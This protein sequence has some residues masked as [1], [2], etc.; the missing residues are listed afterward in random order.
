MITALEDNSIFLDVNL[1]FLTL[2]IPG[3]WPSLLPGKPFVYLAGQLL[4]SLPK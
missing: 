2:N 3:K 4:S 1:T